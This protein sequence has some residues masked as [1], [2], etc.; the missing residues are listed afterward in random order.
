MLVCHPA[1]CHPSCSPNSRVRGFHLGSHV[2]VYYPS[3]ALGE[4]GD[5]KIPNTLLFHY[6]R[7]KRG[8]T[9]GFRC[10]RTTNLPGIANIPSVFSL[11][12][13]LDA[14]N[15]CYHRF[16]ATPF[17]KPNQKTIATIRI[18]GVRLTIDDLPVLPAFFVKKLTEFNDENFR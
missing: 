3:S 1:V 18:R 17:K 9:R 11:L 10:S 5:A 12:G 14:K 2:G 15:R 7:G 6:S 13:G 16:S 4:A 8:K